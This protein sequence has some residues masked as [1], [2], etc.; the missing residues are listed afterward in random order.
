MS[1]F[2]AS[3]FTLAKLADTTHLIIREVHL[4]LA[5]LADGAHLIIHIN[6]LDALL[7]MILDQIM[8]IPYVKAALW[9]LAIIQVALESTMGPTLS[10]IMTYGTALHML[11]LTLY[12]LFRLLQGIYTLV[13]TILLTTTN[14]FLAAFHTMMAAILLFLD[15]PFIILNY[16]LWP[17]GRPNETLCSPYVRRRPE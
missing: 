11:I 8:R 13:K 4:A 5:K 2:R 7:S 14:L 17:Q 15:I 16:F 1:T 10:K 12:L 9:V 3:S 6:H